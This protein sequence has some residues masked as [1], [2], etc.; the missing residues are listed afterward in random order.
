MR[1]RILAIISV[2]VILLFAGCATEPLGTASGNPEVTVQSTNVPR[3]KATLISG[4][5]S[6]G[7]QVT[8]DSPFLLGFV[9]PVNPAAGALYQALMGNAYSSTPQMRVAFN[10]ASLGDST[11]VFGHIA[12]TMQNAFGQSQETNLDRG[13]AGHE[14]QTVLT[15]LKAEMEAHSGSDQ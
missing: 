9:G 3:I 5:A 14:L 4:L 11:R 1:S 6:Q 7:Y 15:Q 2:P 13:K 12:V 10:F 8:Q